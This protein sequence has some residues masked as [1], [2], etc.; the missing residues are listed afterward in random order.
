MGDL[1]ESSQSNSFRRDEYRD[2]CRSVLSC[3]SSIPTSEL[4]VDVGQIRGVRSELTTKATEDDIERELMLSPTA[5]LLLS[6]NRDQDRRSG[7]SVTY[8]E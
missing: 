7:T 6:P 5:S 4:Y 3:K 8:R 1:R 2:L